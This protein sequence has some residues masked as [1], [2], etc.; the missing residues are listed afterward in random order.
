MLEAAPGV[1]FDVGILVLGLSSHLTRCVAADYLRMVGDFVS[2]SG[3]E[4]LSQ[5]SQ[6][7]AT[8]RTYSCKSAEEYNSLFSIQ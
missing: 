1:V 3:I 2:G 7:C 6:Y 4:G 8:C 5:V